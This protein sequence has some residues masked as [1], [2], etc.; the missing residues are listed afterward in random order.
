MKH[1]NLPLPNELHKR[2]KV[3]CALEEKMMTEVIRQL[4]EEYVEKVEKRKLIVL[5]KKK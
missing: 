3:I 5:S 1:V 2:L 4:V